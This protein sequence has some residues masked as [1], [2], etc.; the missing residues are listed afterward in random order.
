MGERQSV[1]LFTGYEPNAGSN[2]RLRFFADSDRLRRRTGPCL[3]LAAEYLKHC[4]RARRA[5][6]GGGFFGD[7]VDDA[8]AGALRAVEKGALFTGPRFEGTGD[9]PQL[10]HETIF[11]RGEGC[12]V[13][14]YIPND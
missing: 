3:T 8:F 13:R 1:W 9:V 5:I 2:R 11:N 7:G 14:R 4:S 6:S 10:R 12:A